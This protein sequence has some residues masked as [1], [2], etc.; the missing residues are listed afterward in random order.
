M[1]KGKP[2]FTGKDAVRQLSDAFLDV[3]ESN[4]IFVEFGDH[5]ARTSAQSYITN[6]KSV[7]QASVACVKGDALG[8]VTPLKEELSVL[9]WSF[10]CPNGVRRTCRI[11]RE[12]C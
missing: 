10:Q 4:K 11:P 3:E 5:F 9:I 2:T 6:F 12:T 1:E 7:L 8:K